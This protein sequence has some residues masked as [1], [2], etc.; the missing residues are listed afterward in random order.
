M[1]KADFF[2]HVLTPMRPVL[3]SSHSPQTVCLPRVKGRSALFS[4]PAA[5]TRR[6]LL[7]TLGMEALGE[8]ARQS[9]QAR[10]ASSSSVSSPATSYSSDPGVINERGEVFVAPAPTPPAA[11]R[12]TLREA[13]HKS[14]SSSS[15][16]RT[17][18][19]RRSA[20]GKGGGDGIGIGIDID[21]DA[22]KG[23]TS[24]RRQQRHGGKRQGNQEDLEAERDGRSSTSR[25]EAAFASVASD[26]DD[27]TLE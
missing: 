5:V 2:I 9:L 12:W 27:G 15:A 22:G 23:G 13:E 20:G 10:R 25:L 8:P 11:H 14:S 7:W 3:T 26:D 24:A 17:S 21:I 6:M 4:L 18:C 1:T 19:A 16:T